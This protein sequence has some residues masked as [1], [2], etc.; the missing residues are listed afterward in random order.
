MS[1]DGDRGPP[2][3]GVVLPAPALGELPQLGGVATD[4]GVHRRMWIDGEELGDVEPRVRVGTA[5]ELRTQQSDVDVASHD[6]SLSIRA[7][8]FDAEVTLLQLGVGDQLGGGGLGLDPAG[9]HHQLPIGHPYGGAKVLLDDEHGDPFGNESVDDVDQ[10]VDDGGRKPLGRL[11]H[12]HQRTVQQQR[13]THGEH[14][15]LASRQLA[16]A[17][18]ASLGEPGEHVVDR[19]DRPALAARAFGE[20]RQVLVDGQRWEQPTTLRHVRDAAPGDLLRDL[21][22]D[23]LAVENDFTGRC[24]RRDP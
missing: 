17:I 16:A 11:V 6:I 22:L 20:H 10:G 4:H 14:L 19:F 7:D 15:L 5:H 13:P 8:A 18:A 12:D 1:S 21:V 24:L 9:H 2:V 3:G 23:S